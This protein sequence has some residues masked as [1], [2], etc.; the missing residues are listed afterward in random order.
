MANDSCGSNPAKP[1]DA[2]KAG[3]RMVKCVKFGK[4]MEGLD[5]VP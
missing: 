2:P 1:A 3:A 5:R 4:E